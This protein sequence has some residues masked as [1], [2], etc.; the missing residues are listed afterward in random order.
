M[1]EEHWFVGAIRDL[2]LISESDGYTDLLAGLTSV[3]QTYVEEANLP[4]D[5]CEEIRRL[6][7]QESSS[8]C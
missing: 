5:Q 1:D 4:P 8:I 2:S 6:L 3:V 7:S